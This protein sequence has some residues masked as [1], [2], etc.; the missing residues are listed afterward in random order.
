MPELDGCGRHEAVGDDCVRDQQRA[1]GDDENEQRGPRATQCCSEQTHQQDRA[2]R[3]GEPWFA[4]DND[5]AV[6]PAR[7]SWIGSIH[8]RRRVKARLVYSRSAGRGCERDD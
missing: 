4:G 3:Q 1:H 2:K 7:R 5:T 8:G 6:L